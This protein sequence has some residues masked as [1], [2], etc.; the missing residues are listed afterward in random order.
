MDSKKLL[1]ISDTHG[2]LKALKAVF[3]WAKERLPPKDSICAAAFLGDGY[4]DIYQVADSTEFSCNWVIVKG[5]NDYSTRDAESAIFDFASHR[6]FACHGH[7]H[8]LYAGNQTLISAAR[9]NGAAIVLSGHTH[10]PHHKT[11]NGILLINPGSVGQPR[12]RI[13]ATFAVIECKEDQ[14][15]KVE[16]LG[17][18]NKGEIKPV[19][20]K[21]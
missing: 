15:L 8:N 20:V 10:V 21:A 9:L 3:N 2:G 11:T 14:P 1:V 19:K 16:F 7:R 5:N 18:D 13:G 6:F 12:S 4:D 17:I